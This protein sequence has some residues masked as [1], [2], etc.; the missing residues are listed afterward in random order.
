VAATLEAPGA[1][2]GVASA[3]AIRIEGLSKRYRKGALAN[4]GIDLRIERG[5]VFALLGP[6]GAGKTTLVRQITSELSPTSGRIEVLG[7]DVLR[8][9]LKAKRL[10]GVVPQEAMPY[11][12]LRPE[13][14]LSLFGRLHGLSRKDARARAQ[15]LM[16][17]LDLAPH[18]AKVAQEL[19]GGL[20]RKLLVGIA[21]MAEPPVLVLDEPT[22]GLDPHSR[23]EVWELI[24]S[25]KDQGATTLITTHY[26][27]EAEELADSV[28]VI[29]AGRILARGTIAELRERC[30]NRYK[31]VYEDESGHRHTVYGQTQPEVVNQLEQAG[32]V[33]YS[34]MRA[35]LEDLYLELTG[36]TIEEAAGA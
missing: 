35:S 32:A 7:I 4:D 1:T 5:A 19:S 13:E 31:G 36:E 29:G 16:A 30:R 8:E 12:H 10:M 25:L 17:A 27:D 34:V 22:T 9:P 2:A 21:M 3:P 23:R 14:H 28:A 24:R 11:P 33:E 26:M 6:N 18:A 20:K 15:T